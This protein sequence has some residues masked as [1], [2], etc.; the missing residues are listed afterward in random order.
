VD[1]LGRLVS[2]TDTT[3]KRTT[4]S[5]DQVGRHT[6]TSTPGWATVTNGYDPNSGWLANV[7]ANTTVLATTTFVG[8]PAA[9]MVSSGLLGNRRDHGPGLR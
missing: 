8:R 3:N 1:L 9:R 6:S 7:T 4:L 2:Y 5:Y